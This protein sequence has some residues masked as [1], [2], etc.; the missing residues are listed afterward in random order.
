MLQ[1]VVQTYSVLRGNGEKILESE[2]ME[3]VCE[4][5]ARGAVDLVHGERDG[6]ANL[7]Q[8]L[9]QIAIGARNFGPSVNQENDLRGPIQRHAGLLQNLAGY[10]LGV[11]LYD[12]T[13]IDEGKLASQILSLATDTVTRDARFVAHNR[14]A[15]SRDRVE[16]GR[17]ADVG[18][19]DNH[20]H[21]QRGDFSWR[22][23]ACDH[24]SSQIG[25]YRC[26]PKC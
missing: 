15:G 2:R 8:H 12:S 18:T 5:L 10:Q 21:G 6:L 9:G 14:P 25:N 17:F 4:I 3:F 7:P 13:G 22:I 24:R 20:H 1:Q 23:W 26:N 19:A 11:V 16:Q